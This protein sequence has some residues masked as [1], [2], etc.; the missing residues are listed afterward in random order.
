MSDAEVEIRQSK[1]KPHNIFIIKQL[2]SF[3]KPKTT[4]ASSKMCE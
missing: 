4:N 3:H 2:V 1:L